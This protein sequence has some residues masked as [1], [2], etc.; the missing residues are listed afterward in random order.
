MDEVFMCEALKKEN[1]TKTYIPLKKFGVYV[2]MFLC[3]SFIFFI[4]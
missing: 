1:K 3:I 2:C 4:D